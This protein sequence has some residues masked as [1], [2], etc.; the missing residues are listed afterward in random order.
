M[1][2][3]DVPNRPGISDLLTKASASKRFREKLFADPQ[4][5]CQEQQLDEADT[6]V[7]V[8][9]VQASDPKTLPEVARQIKRLLTSG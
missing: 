1:T 3:Q 5:A 9:A 2:T 7:V 6:K 8:D 4:A